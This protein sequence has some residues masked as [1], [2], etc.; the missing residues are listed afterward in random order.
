MVR[1]SIYCV[2][3]SLQNKHTNIVHIIPR[4]TTRAIHMV[5]DTLLCTLALCKIKKLTSFLLAI[6]YC[7]KFIFNFFMHCRIQAIPQD[8]HINWSKIPSQIKHE[9]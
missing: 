3:Y 8:D 1:K 7:C 9:I 2:M 5:V 4:I 6:S